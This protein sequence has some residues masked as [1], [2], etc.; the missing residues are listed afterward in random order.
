MKRLFNI[1][2]SVMAMSSLTGCDLMMTL[3]E[4]SSINL[5]YV[6]DD[7]VALGEYE[8]SYTLRFSTNASWRASSD[9]EWCT[10]SPSRGD[11]SVTEVTVTVAK[12]TVPDIRRAVVILSTEDSQS[13]A[14]LNVIQDQM[15][16]VS[17]AEADYE[18]PDEGGV[19][20]VAMQHNVR[21]KV[22]ISPDAPWIKMKATKAVS[23]TAHEF[24]VDP[25]PEEVSRTGTISFEDVSGAVTE[26]VTVFQHGLPP[27]R[28][29]VMKV[30]HSNDI[31]NVPLFNEGLTGMIY[32]GIDA[33]GDSFGSVVG[34]DY[35]QSGEK[36]VVTFD[37]TG[38]HNK[39]IVE[40][41]DIEG[42]EEIDLSGF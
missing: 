39:F 11:K 14:I 2:L 3:V 4:P 35:G 1:L 25:N 40:F 15:T 10:V 41:Q 38:Y 26:V 23:T 31:F 22:T 8:E 13:R 17:A 6:N 29:L 33:P 9:S 30:T 24:T 5:K 21:Y 37:L 7:K 42:I 19:F 28:N 16:F 32:W 27:K 12:N 18:L 20:K 36:K 34:Y